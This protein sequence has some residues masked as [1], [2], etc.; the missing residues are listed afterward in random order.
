MVTELT[1]G[2]ALSVKLPL[3]GDD[4]PVAV[5]VTVPVTLNV[6]DMGPPS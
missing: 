6:V 5:L 1:T 3:N 4:W 2:G